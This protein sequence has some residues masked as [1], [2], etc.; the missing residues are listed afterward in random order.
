METVEN[1]VEEARL[2]RDTGK[3]TV[4]ESDPIRLV[5]LGESGIGKSTL[6]SRVFGISEE[7]VSSIYASVCWFEL[8]WRFR[9]ASAMIVQENMILRSESHTRRTGISWF[10]IAVDF[11]VE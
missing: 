8:N 6:I 2:N 10:M 1:L 5:I 9:Q 3:E 11:P 7:E 4:D